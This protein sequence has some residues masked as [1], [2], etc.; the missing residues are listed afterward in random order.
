MT[1]TVKLTSREPSAQSFNEAQRWTGDPRTENALVAAHDA[2]PD[3]ATKALEELLVVCAAVAGDDAR[4]RA[5]LERF[6][7]TPEG[8]AL[9]RQAE[10]S[11]ST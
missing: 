8:A 2:A 7:A 10:N 4:V 1:K 6:N 11:G 3:D 5:A 9:I